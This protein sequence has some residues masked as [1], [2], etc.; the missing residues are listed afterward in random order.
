MMVVET[1]DVDTAV[2]SEL[3]YVYVLYS[4]QILHI[5]GDRVVSLPARKLLGRWTASV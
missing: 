1:L 3:F 5:E 2:M 4:L